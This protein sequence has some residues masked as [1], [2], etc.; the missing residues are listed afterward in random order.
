MVE[1]FWLGGNELIINFDGK[2]CK[3]LERYENYNIVFAGSYEK[4]K[5]YCENRV[6]EYEESIIG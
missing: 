1:N 4:C 6:V 5:K 2:N 3:V